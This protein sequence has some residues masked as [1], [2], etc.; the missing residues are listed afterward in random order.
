M[1][2]YLDVCPQAIYLI[3]PR[4]FSS[5]YNGMIIITLQAAGSAKYLITF[6]PNDEEALKLKLLNAFFE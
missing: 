4:V 5:S 6:L 1:G 3:L 2:H